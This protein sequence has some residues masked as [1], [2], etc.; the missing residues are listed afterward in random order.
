MCINWLTQRSQLQVLTT[1]FWGKFDLTRIGER[2]VGYSVEDIEHTLSTVGVECNTQVSG[3]NALRV[4]PLA[5]FS[6]VSNA[7]I[8]GERQADVDG[9]LA[10]LAALP[11]S[12][13][14]CSYYS[15]DRQSRI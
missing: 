8:I 6:R 1:D 10:A 12:A 2:S 9:S 5:D 3:M 15:V 7:I 13:S 4:T 14:C 11:L